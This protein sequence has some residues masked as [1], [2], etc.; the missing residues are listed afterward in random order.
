[1]SF[2]KTAKRLH[3]LEKL[4]GEM[5]DNTDEDIKQEILAEVFFPTIDM[6]CQ[7]MIIALRVKIGA[8][9]AARAI[10]KSKFHDLVEYVRGRVHWERT[11]VPLSLA[12][13]DVSG[14]NFGE[15]SSAAHSAWD[16]AS[17]CGGQPYVEPTAFG[18]DSAA[19]GCGEPWGQHSGG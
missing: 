4:R 3:E 16:V 6:A 7:S 14:A 17:A 10:D 9:M 2:A 5:C 19:S 18:G 15:N 12:K 8:G 11:L 13:M 1:M